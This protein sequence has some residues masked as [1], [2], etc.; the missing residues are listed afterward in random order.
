LQ[1]EKKTNN[2]FLRGLKEKLS[3]TNKDK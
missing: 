2:S 3:N 1:F